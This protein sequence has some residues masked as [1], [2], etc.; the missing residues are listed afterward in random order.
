[1]LTIRDLSKTYA[2]GVHDGN[3]YTSLIVDHYGLVSGAKRV[4]ERFTVHGSS[5]TV[6]TA[7][8]R[9]KRIKGSGTI[10]I[11]LEKSTGALVATGTVSS[12][13]IPISPLPV[14]VD[15]VHWDETSLGG[16]R[17]VKASFGKSVTLRS[18]STYILKIS[19]ASSTVLAAVPV[20]EQDDTTPHWRSRAFRDGYAQYT[21]GST[22]KALYA[23][24]P[25]DLQFYLR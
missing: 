16:G 20:R 17:W 3:A 7:S 2:N 12:T 24:G 23:Y 14:P 8:I 18:G 11:R 13:H 19:T 9:L 21:T 10:T 6:S 4:A 22:W 5:R 15:G 1:M 25:A